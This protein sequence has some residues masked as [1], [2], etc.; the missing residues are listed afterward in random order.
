VTLAKTAVKRALLAAVAAKV[1]PNSTTLAADSP[2]AA[3][4]V[5]G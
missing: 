3:A 1:S 2:L 5:R 4:K